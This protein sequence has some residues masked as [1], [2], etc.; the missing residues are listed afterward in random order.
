MTKHSAEEMA[1]TSSE[2]AVSSNAL[3][4]EFSTWRGAARVILDSEAGLVHFGNCHRT[5]KLFARPSGWYSCRISDLK[6]VHCF[7]GNL[8]AS[9]AI[10][11]AWIPASATCYDEL[12]KYLMEAAPAN[13]PEFSTDN[14]ITLF[15]YIGSLMLGVILGIFLMPPDYG[16]NWM[17]VAH[18]V[19]SFSGWL[20]CYILF[21]LSGRFLKIDLAQP[22]GNGFRWA[23]FV[24]PFGFLFGNLGP[25]IIALVGALGVID[26]VRKRRK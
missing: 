22:L 25:V 23:F 16:S 2:P 1:Q 9:T 14:P 12:R 17:N 21:L 13:Q 5:R 20:P 19:G 10:G 7:D 11:I 15:A 26:G 8:T 18:V 24:I 3:I 4:C 6:A